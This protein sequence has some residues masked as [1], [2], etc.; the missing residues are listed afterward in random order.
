MGGAGIAQPTAR[1]MTTWVRFPAGQDFPF[2][3]RDD[4][5][6]QPDSYPM[7][8]GGDVPGGKAARA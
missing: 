2:L 3:H 7:G 6:A 1:I 8:T 5:G 4:S